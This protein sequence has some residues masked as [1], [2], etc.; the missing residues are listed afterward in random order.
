MRIRSA[1][2][3]IAAVLPVGGG[4]TGPTHVLNGEY[5]VLVV[6]VSSTRVVLGQHGTAVVGYDLATP[7]ATSYPSAGQL[8]CGQAS[9][10]R[11]RIYLPPDSSSSFAGTFTDSTV[12]GTLTTST[13]TQPALLYG[14]VYEPVFIDGMPGA[15]PAPPSSC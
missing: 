6:G 10:N 12:T 15:M 13:G 3:M 7:P 4:S 5:V 11:L 14:P 8:V 2:G 9:G 1:L